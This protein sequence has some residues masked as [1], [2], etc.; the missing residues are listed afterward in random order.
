[1]QYTTHLVMLQSPA[2]GPAHLGPGRT[3]LKK[4]K[5]CSTDLEGSKVVASRASPGAAPGAFALGFPWLRLY[6]LS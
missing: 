2:D 6:L 4:D 5:I 3:G 1:M